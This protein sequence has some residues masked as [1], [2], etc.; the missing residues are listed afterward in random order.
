V[1]G[2]AYLVKTWGANREARSD[3]T[4]EESPANVSS[5]P[6]A[7]RPTLYDPKDVLAAINR[8]RDK[9]GLAPLRLA[10]NSRGCQEHADY[11]ARNLPSRPDLDLHS[12]DP[13]LPGATPEGA[14][15]VSHV[16]VVARPPLEAVKTWFDAP[17]HRDLLL[18]PA[19]GSVGIGFARQESGTWLS[20]FDFLTGRTAQGSPASVREGVLFPAHQ[21]NEVPLVFPGNEIPDPLPMT[22]E[23]L[24][25]YPVTV[26]FPPRL[27][28]AGARARLE[29][30][31]GQEV[32]LWFSCPET[33]ANK[34][35]PRSQQN[36]LCLFSREPLRPGTRYLVRAQARLGA[37]DWSRTWSFVTLPSD[38][39]APLAYRRA[40]ARI[41]QVRKFSGLEP[42]RLDQERSAGCIAH[43]R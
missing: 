37:R 18:D 43:A 29:D 17:A 38:R 42:L 25:G 4:G 34:D 28:V 40:L 36:T 10:S 21:Q 39:T 41:N 26:T 5:T 16:S 20:V 1:G 8:H 32:P 14:A 24:A 13:A 2:A 6:P 22:K 30:E 19:L 9:T 7:P 3:N 23:K 15:V 11:L 33:P 35:H 27:S 31:A 12:Q